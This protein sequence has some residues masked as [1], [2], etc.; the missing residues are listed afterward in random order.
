MSS[1]STNTATRRIVAAG[2]LVLSLG[3][4]IASSGVPTTARAEPSNEKIKAA[5]AQAAEA[6]ERL[7]ALA[8][9]LEERGEEY[10]AVE[11]Q[12]A[13]TRADLKHAQGDLE[14]AETVEAEAEAAFDARVNAMYRRGRVDMLSVVLGVEDFRDLVTMLDLLQRVGR[15]DAAVVA[16]VE[17]ARR[18]ADRIRNVLDNRRTEQVVLLKAAAAKKRQVEDVHAQQKRYLAGIDKRLSRLIA[19][20]RERQEKIA[21][22]RAAAAAANAAGRGGR[23]FDP[24]ALGEGHP[25][26]LAVAR[27]FVGV[28][29]YVWGGTT[30]AGFDCSGLTMY[31]YRQ[32]GVNIPRTS[33]EQYR[34]GAFIPPDRLDL[35]KPGD[36]VF[37]G[38]GGDP[39]RVHHV[40]MFAGGD[41]FVHAPQTGMRVSVSSL[42]ARIQE[43]GDYVGATRP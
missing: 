32:I 7:D 33:R 27:R 2:F 35:L 15:S 14:E 30:P 41:D 34:F 31:S 22:A 42:R 28:T 23:P 39:N 36:L 8:A 40:G 43:R 25:G 38:R 9:D 16:R 24:A 20:E 21:Q 19:Q 26:A 6:R 11:S 3:V 18:A 4:L 12:L 10:L 5:R 37:F 17:D 13:R 29:P 1:T